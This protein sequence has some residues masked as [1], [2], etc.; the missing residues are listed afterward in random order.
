MFDMTTIGRRIAALRKEKGLSQMELADAMGIS[1]QSVSNWERGNTMPDISRL[2]ELAGILG[3]TVDGLLGETTE[4]GVIEK[5][6]DE[7][8]VLSLD[9]FKEVAP[10]LK[11]EQ[12]RRR[13][14]ETRKSEEKSSG[15]Q[16]M[17]ISDLVM[18]SPFLD[19]DVLSEIAG[20]LTE[21]GRVGDLVGIAPFLEQDKLDA[22]AKKI[23]AD[24]ATASELVML[25]PFMSKEA[26]SELAAEALRSGGDAAHN[27]TEE[28]SGGQGMG[29]SD[30]VM[31]APFLEDDTLSELATK[32]AAEG[33]MAELT[34]LAPFVQQDTLDAL[35]KEVASDEVSFNEL[36]TLVPYISKEALSALTADALR[37]G[38]TPGE[39]VR[40]Q[41]ERNAGRD[42][43]SAISFFRV[44]RK[45]KNK[46]N[47]PDD[48]ME[49]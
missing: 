10:L 37:R 6:M 24:Q 49:G 13:F 4:A 48:S 39:N 33:R 29:I 9:E 28:G 26:L 17:N 20:N 8:A 27:N 47:P 34:G 40:R 22:L 41:A 42:A 44:N 38:V 32:L 12:A 1:F 35:V 18:L 45:S 7:T 21:E 2:P 16:G 19:D 11:P 43:A 30:L 25:A 5:A 46:P 31:L 14:D 36:V 23:A 15:G 3:V